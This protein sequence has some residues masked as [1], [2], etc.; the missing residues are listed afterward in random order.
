MISDTPLEAGN[1][2]SLWKIPQ[3]HF[4][5]WVSA[6]SRSRQGPPAVRTL[7]P[8]LPIWV[9]PGGLLVLAIPV[10]TPDPGPHPSEADSRMPANNASPTPS[11]SSPPNQAIDNSRR[12]GTVV[13]NSSSFPS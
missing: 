9:L 5:K 1:G 7:A 3:H 12:E 8:E 13:F 6:L 4:L 11:A 10:V 2:I